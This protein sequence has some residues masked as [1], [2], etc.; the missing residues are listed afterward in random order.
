MTSVNITDTGSVAYV[1]YDPI[2]KTGSR[3]NKLPDGQLRVIMNAEDGGRGDADGLVNGSISDQ[4][5]PG[6][7]AI[8]NMLDVNSNILTVGDG[9]NSNNA[10]AAQFLKVSLNTQAKKTYDVIAVPFAPEIGRAHV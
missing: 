6:E 1:N 4:C 7:T 8:S 10:I 3:F 9:K 5:A 2:T